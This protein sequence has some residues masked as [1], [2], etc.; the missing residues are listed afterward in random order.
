MSARAGVFSE[1]VVVERSHFFVTVGLWSAYSSGC[2]L[3]ATDS[4]WGLSSGSGHV[5]FSIVA[6]TTIAP[7]TPQENLNFS[8][9]GGPV[10][11]KGF[12]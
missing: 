5:T 12:T 3:E 6:L 9:H 1:V 2:W 4:S 8:P 7:S 11:F 10:S